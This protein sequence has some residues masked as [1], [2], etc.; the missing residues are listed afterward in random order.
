MISECF[1]PSCRRE[2]TYLRDGRVVRIIRDDPS[3]RLRVEHFWLCGSCNLQYDFCFTEG[4]Q[5]DGK[6]KIRNDRLVAVAEVNHMYANIRR[7]KDLPSKWL[8]EV[9]EFF[10]N[11][12][13]LEGKSISC[14]D[15][16]DKK[17]VSV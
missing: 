5:L 17:R 6:K 4:V 11:Y 10:V 12:H 16:R 7:L 1:N 14:W 8:D 13:G 15:A 9:Q 3:G 2:L